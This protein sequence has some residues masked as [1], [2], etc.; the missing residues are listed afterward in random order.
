MNC[1]LDSI[2]RLSQTLFASFRTAPSDIL[3]SPGGSVDAAIDPK[4]R[5]GYIVGRTDTFE[6]D[7]EGNLILKDKFDD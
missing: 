3:S 5:A 6:I 4:K 1:C 2:E 7:P